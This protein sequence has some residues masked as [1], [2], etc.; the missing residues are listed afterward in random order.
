[1]QSYWIADWVAQQ[2]VRHKVPP[3]DH[4][5]RLLAESVWAGDRW[6][7]AAGLLDGAELLRGMAMAAHNTPRGRKCQAYAQL[8]HAFDRDDFERYIASGYFWQVHPPPPSV[9]V[10]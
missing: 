9:T 10:G 6:T 4:Q 7:E 5:E 3:G 8:A 2:F 1:M